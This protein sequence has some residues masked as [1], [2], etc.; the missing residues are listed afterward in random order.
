MGDL[1]KQICLFAAAARA[2]NALSGQVRRGERVMNICRRDSE[3]K[4]DGK[5]VRES[6]REGREEDRITA[7]GCSCACACVA[8]IIIIIITITII[9]YAI[10]YSSLIIL[11]LLPM[12]L[13]LFTWCCWIMLSRA[14]MI[15]MH[16]SVS[17]FYKK[18]VTD[19][20]SLVYS[21]SHSVLAL[22][23]ISRWLVFI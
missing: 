5:T 12:P 6:W 22:K 13:V 21:V 23:F 3:R 4:S 16:T 17:S 7:D 10:I 15:Y 2:R 11:S 1:E 14:I 20:L 18:D 8:V 9:S 19:Y